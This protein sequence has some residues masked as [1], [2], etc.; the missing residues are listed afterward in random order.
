M[1]GARLNRSLSAFGGMKSSLKS[2][3]Q[4]VGGRVQQAGEAEADALPLRMR[5]RG[6]ARR[7]RSDANEHRAAPTRGAD[8][9]RVGAAASAMRHEEPATCATR[10][11]KKMSAA[12][13]RDRAL[14]AVERAARRARCRRSRSQVSQISST[15]SW[16]NSS[17]ALASRRAVDA[18]LEAEP[19]TPA[20][21]AA[22]AGATSEPRDDASAARPPRGSG[23]RGPE[24]SRSGGGRPRWRPPPGSGRKP[25]T[26]AILTSARTTRRRHGAISLR[27]QRCG[28][29]SRRRRR[30]RLA[31]W[32]RAHRRGAT[33][34][35]LLP[36]RRR[37]RAPR[38]SS[39]DQLPR[40]A[41]RRP[42]GCDRA[43]ALLRE[44]LAVDERAVGLGPARRRAARRAPRSASGPSCA[45]IA[46][47]PLQL[48][49]APAAPR[50]A[51]LGRSRA[52]CTCV[53][54][55]RLDARSTRSANGSAASPPGELRARPRVFGFLSA[56]MRMSSPCPCGRPV[57]KTSPRAE[58]GLAPASSSAKLSSLRVL[59]AEHDGDLARSRRSWPS[60]CCFAAAS[61]SSTVASSPPTRASSTRS[62]WTR[63]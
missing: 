33:L 3:L 12:R 40:R 14:E 23:R 43:L 54:L 36:A 35:E 47:T 24:S 32:P 10:P 53:D 34:G 29:P 52:R 45:A 46:T 22:T 20:R 59:R 11:P 21:R 39:R 15:A 6:V 17:A 31:A 44:A 8:G 1:I 16:L 56:L 58:V 57:T 19:S 63:W 26:T 4:A 62:S 51:D 41:R 7:T 18:R 50:A 38:A 28:S 30:R 55:A 49:R 5:E 25:M 37:S 48:A 42:A 61:A 13:P 27:C 60:S 2:S 9:R